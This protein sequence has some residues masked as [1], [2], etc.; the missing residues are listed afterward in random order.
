MEKTHCGRQLYSAIVPA[1]NIS[2]PYSIY[3]VV[4]KFDFNSDL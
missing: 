4:E 1:N 3:A 2:Y